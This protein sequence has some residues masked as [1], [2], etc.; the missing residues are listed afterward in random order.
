ML[1][2]LNFIHPNYEDIKTDIGREIIKNSN[3]IKL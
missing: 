3:Y 1:F 2:F